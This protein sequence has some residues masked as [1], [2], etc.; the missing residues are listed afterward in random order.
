MATTPQ[1]MPIPSYQWACLAADENRQSFYL[2]GSSTVGNLDVY[3]VT[4]IFATQVNH[5]ATQNNIY[6]WS[7]DSRKACFRSPTSKLVNGPIKITQFGLANTFHTTAYPDGKV[8]AP[9]YYKDQPTTFVSPKLFAW[10]GQMANYDLFTVFTNYISPGYSQ[11]ASN[12]QPFEGTNSSSINRFDLSHYPVADPL[13]ALGTYTPSTGTNSTGFTIVFDKLGEALAYITTGTSATSL[14]NTTPSMTL[15]P[16]IRVNMSNIVL[17]ENAIPVTMS[18]T[19]YILDRAKDGF[20]TVVYS[21]TPSKS[22]A[23]Q[24]VVNTGPSPPFANNMAAAA[25][26]Q[27]IITYTSP[28]GANGYFNSFDTVTGTWSGQNLVAPRKSSSSNSTPVGAIVGGVLGGLILFAMFIILFIRRRHQNTCKSVNIAQPEVGNI[29]ATSTTDDM[30]GSGLGYIQY[31]PGYPLPP[32]FIPPPPFSGHN[33]SNSLKDYDPAHHHMYRSMS[34]ESDLTVLDP[35]N[36]NFSSYVSPY[37]YRESQMT[38][39]SRMVPNSPEMRQV[40]PRKSSSS[41]RTQGPQYIPGATIQEGIPNYPQA[42]LA[43]DNVN[44]AV[45]V[46]G[47]PVSSASGHEVN[48]VSIANINSPTTS[49]LGYRVS[50][51]NEPQYILSLGGR[52]VECYQGSWREMGN[53]PSESP[54]IAVGTVSTAANFSKSYSVVFDTAGMGQAF[55]AAGSSEAPPTT[56]ASI[57]LLS[58]PVDVNMNGIKLTADSIPGTMGSSGYIVDKTPDGFMEVFSITPEESATLKHVFSTD[59]NPPFF[60]SMAS[61]A[62]TNKSSPTD[63]PSK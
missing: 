20:S 51:E 35:T 33:D 22:Y 50:P 55:L 47:V 4:D 52:A 46:I 62:L 27:R 45:Y 30:D 41:L 7:S 29:I 39:T 36:P 43:A 54:L 38:N 58:V 59:G 8:D 24:E 61:T 3:Y 5:V 18:T 6:A 32:S 10:S 9:E 63:H 56:E 11:W 48:Y 15:S 26:S 14:Y 44:S 60:S 40:E 31:A 16:S 34:A 21:I 2:V 53:Y 57:L 28:P 1:M 12:L 49:A 42:C 13:L 37:S 17:T 19:G 25:L 23:L